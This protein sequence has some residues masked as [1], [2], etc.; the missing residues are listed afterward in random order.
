[1]ANGL[2]F[3][4]DSTE[5]VGWKNP[6]AMQANFKIKQNLLEHLAQNNEKRLF[7]IKF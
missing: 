3:H 7:S 6:I 1:M 4:A 2:L 5:D